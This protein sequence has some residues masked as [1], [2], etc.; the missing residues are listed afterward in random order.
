MGLLVVVGKHYFTPNNQQQ[1]AIRTFKATS[2]LLFFITTAF[3]IVRTTLKPKVLNLA[4]LS[5]LDNLPG[6]WNDPYRVAAYDDV[7]NVD[8]DSRESHLAF[9][10]GSLNKIT[11]KLEKV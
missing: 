5:P 1:A 7:H 6:I 11:L 2:Q 4:F 8:V 10:Q 9:S 3:R